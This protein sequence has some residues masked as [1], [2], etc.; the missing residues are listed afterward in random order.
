LVSLGTP[1]DSLYSLATDVSDSGQFIVGEYEPLANTYAAFIWDGT[2]GF[3]SLQSVLVNDYG[4]DLTGWVLESAAAISGDGTSI[5]GFG[6]YNGVH[7]GWVVSG[8]VAV[9]E[10]HMWGML[11]GALALLAIVLRRRKAGRA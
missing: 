9:P 2:N 10:P 4:V 3:R 5:T 7:T 8:I 1:V 6:L 11:S